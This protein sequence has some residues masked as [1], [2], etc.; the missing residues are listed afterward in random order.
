M[1][2]ISPYKNT[3]DIQPCPMPETLENSKG[4][5]GKHIIICNFNIVLKEQWK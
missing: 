4:F 3:I 2:R 5:R 1:Y